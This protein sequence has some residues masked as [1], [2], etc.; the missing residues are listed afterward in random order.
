MQVQKPQVLYPSD[1][2]EFFKYHELF[3][4]VKDDIRNDLVSS[5]KVQV[6]QSGENIIREGEE[7]YAMF[8]ILKGSVCVQSD[9]LEA[10][11]AE[12]GPGSFF[13]EVGML[14][15]IKRTATVK[16]MT[17]CITAVL[18]AEVL[19]SILS[20]TPDLTGRIMSMARDR[21]EQTRTTTKNR[22]SVDNANVLDFIESHQLFKDFEGS[23]KANLM[24][25]FVTKHISPDHVQFFSLKSPDLVYV[26]NGPIIV[27]NEQNEQLMTIDSDSVF[28]GE[29]QFG[30][31]LVLK[32]EVYAVTYWIKLSLIGDDLDLNENET[33]RFYVVSSTEQLEDHEE[34]VVLRDNYETQSE[35]PCTRESAPESVVSRL[36]ATATEKRRASIAVWSDLFDQLNFPSAQTTSLGRPESC[37]DDVEFR[38]EQFQMESEQSVDD[39]Q[40]DIL[41]R[42]FSFLPFF[43]LLNCRTVC[44]SWNEGTENLIACQ[45]VNLTPKNKLVDNETLDFVVNFCGSRPTVLSVRNCWLLTNASFFKIANSMPNLTKLDLHSCWEITTAGI[46]AITSR[47]TKLQTLEL[48]NCRK[49]DDE[50]VELISKL[51]YIKHLGFSYCK[52]LTDQSMM[53]LS[54]LKTSLKSLN[55]QR[56]SGITDQGFVR[57]MGIFEWRNLEILNLAD[58]SFLTDEAIKSVC[59]A[60]PVLKN[61]N[62]SF[63]C[64]LSEEAITVISKNAFRLQKLDLSYCGNAVSEKSL[65][66]LCSLPRLTD[67]S[68]RGCVRVNEECLKIVSKIKR[69]RVNVS[70]CKEISSLVVAKFL[71]DDTEWVV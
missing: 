71:S 9:A 41:P 47:C 38:F 40:D 45:T 28:T 34:T 32:S 15:N 64:A 12:L 5:M 3:S 8:F 53:Y 1:L 50:S 69:S 52:N 55:L 23:K 60:C 26:R 70:S 21:Y 19:G 27:Y 17:R 25:N 46:E 11:L 14:F 39:I 13:G 31:F 66:Q 22:S 7:S 61:L 18:S 35:S 36:I 4:M 16:A 44:Q 54:A 49:I 56:C 59:T 37:I 65:R 10:I 2:N 48:G 33:E 29:G 43:D 58:C 68:L 20:D 63:C 6:Y 51:P 62:L 30:E 24:N 57:S 67:L 42:I